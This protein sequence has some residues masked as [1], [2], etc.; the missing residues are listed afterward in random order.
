MNSDPLG[1]MRAIFELGMWISDLFECPQDEQVQER[2]TDVEM[3]GYINKSRN[4]E[5]RQRRCTDQ[6][7][8]HESEILNC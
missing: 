4:N 8:V 3:V 7:T 2:P 5:I 1:F 6:S